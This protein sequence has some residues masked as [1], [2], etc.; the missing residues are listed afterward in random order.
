MTSFK[1]LC[2]DVNDTDPAFGEFWS[3]LLGVPFRP[4]QGADDPGNLIGDPEGQGIAFCPV[5]EPKTVK[6][7]VHL[8]VH[9][10]SLDDVLALGATVQQEHERWTV[11]L[12]PWGN[13]FCAFVRD[14]EL[15]AYRVYELG[16]DAADAERIARWWAD[17]FG[18]EARNDGQSWWWVEGVEGMPFES[19]VFEHVPETKTV[20]NRMHWDV[21]GD[22]AELEAKGAARLWDV[23]RGWVVLTDPEGN[24]FCVF[25]PPAG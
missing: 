16:V 13:E 4:G 24:E 5:P 23:P 11:C 17:V 8:D 20:K 18:V 19:I 7:R 9:V 10:N 1:E 6:N 3:G 22:V 14:H 15:P 12:D 21:Y 2:F 25:T